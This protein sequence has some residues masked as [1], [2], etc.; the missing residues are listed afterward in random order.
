MTAA[1]QSLCTLWTETWRYRIDPRRL[2]FDSLTSFYVIW[3]L[4]HLKQVL[5][6]CLSQICVLAWWGC[7]RVQDSCCHYI[8]V[9]LNPKP[10]HLR[11]A[12]LLLGLTLDLNRTRS[13]KLCRFRELWNQ[14]FWEGITYWKLDSPIELLAKLAVKLFNFECSQMLVWEYLSS[15]LKY[16]HFLHFFRCLFLSPPLPNTVHRPHFILP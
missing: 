4:P 12:K 15:G 10:P 1:L 11:L 3:C 16:G 9:M 6:N 14:K 13:L 7:W 2:W 5:A 8:L